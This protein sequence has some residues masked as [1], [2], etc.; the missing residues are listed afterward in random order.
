M[1]ILT[2][3]TRRTETPS[4]FEVVWANGLAH[5]GT[6]LVH[7]RHPDQDQEVAAEIGAIHHLL[8][9]KAI[10]GSDR[11]GRAKSKGDEADSIESPSDRLQLRVSS[12]QVRKLMQGSSSKRHLFPLAFFLETRFGGANVMTTRDDSWIRPRASMHVEEITVSGALDDEQD[13]PSVGT[14]VLTRHALQQLQMRGNGMDAASAWHQMRHI[15][16]SLDAEIAVTEEKRRRDIERYGVSGRR[17]YSSFT[18]WSVV[19][20]PPDGVDRQLP[21]IA[22]AIFEGRAPKGVGPLPGSDARVTG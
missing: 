10:F 18:G 16:R 17:L 21:T 12:G 2:V 5:Q 20:T 6:L 7:V 4:S 9:R 13:V 15:L 8:V 11:A 19:V 14:A 3:L 22:T 1:N